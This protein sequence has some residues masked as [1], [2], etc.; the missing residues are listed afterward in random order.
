MN[1]NQTSSHTDL[2]ALLCYL[3]VPGWVVGALVIK[4]RPNDFRLYHLRQG[5]GLILLTFLLFVLVKWKVLIVFLY[6]VC[7]VF[8]WV[9]VFSNNRNGIP[10]FG[11]L[12]DTWFKAL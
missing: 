6:I 4:N 5:L 1:A 7:A 11:N 8:G 2:A 9:H 12:F 10:I 3:W